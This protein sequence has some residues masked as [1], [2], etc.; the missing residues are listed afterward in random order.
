MNNGQQRDRKA[1]VMF[2]IHE[3]EDNT[4]FEEDPWEEQEKRD[5]S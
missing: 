4:M 3:S 5:K 2:N 1:T